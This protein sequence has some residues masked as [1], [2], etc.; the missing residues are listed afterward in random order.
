MK[1]K[2]FN[3]L[4]KYNKLIFFHYLALA[5]LL[6]IANLFILRKGIYHAIFHSFLF[7]GAILL[8]SSDFA[9]IKKFKKDGLPFFKSI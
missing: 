3:K 7:A 8:A 6:L 5:S 2:F 1:S 4:K 9:F